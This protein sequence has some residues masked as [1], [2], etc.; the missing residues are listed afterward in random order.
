[1]AI[2]TVAVK[3]T[4]AAARRL[5]NSARRFLD[6]LD[7]AQLEEAQRPFEDVLRFEWNYVPVLRSGLRLDAMTGPQRKRA[8]ELLDAALSVRGARQARE[9]IDHEAVLGEWEA[10]S[11]VEHDTRVMLARNPLFYYFSV[12]GEPGG[13]DP[14]GIKVGGHHIGVNINVIDGDYIA[15]VP[16]FLGANPAEVKHGPKIGHRILAEEEDLARALLRSLSPDQKRLAIVDPVAPFDILTVNYRTI[17]PG[18]TP[19]G[20]PFQNLDGEQRARLARLV[21]HYVDRAAEDVAGTQWRRIERTE[22]GQS[23]FAWAGPER[24]GSGHYYTIGSPGFVIEYDNVQ[25]QANHI[26]SVW[27]DFSNDWGG[28]LLAAHYRDHESHHHH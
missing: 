18:M 4:P 2:E 8:K 25:N 9:I 21:K 11:G 14:W 10:M 5:V 15:P 24:K 7:A 16:L 26:H 23:G 28:D 17:K 12:F 3:R 1:M 27:R 20:I 13:S 22:L 6:A 19:K